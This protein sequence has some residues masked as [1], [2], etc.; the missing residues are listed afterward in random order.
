MQL[1]EG[2]VK[3]YFCGVYLRKELENVILSFEK[4]FCE[5]LSFQ[6]ILIFH[7]WK[8]KKNNKKN[9]QRCCLHCLV[10]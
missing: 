8:W 9:Q 4:F 7:H 1:S 5:S 6:K 10:P 2:G 3:Q